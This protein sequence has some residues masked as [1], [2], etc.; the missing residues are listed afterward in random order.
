MIVSGAGRTVISFVGL[1]GCNG[2]GGDS[3]PAARAM[4]LPPA[5]ASARG[6]TPV[7]K[8]LADTVSVPSGFN[9]TVLYRLGPDHGRDGRRS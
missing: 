8:S 6:F 2:D 3:T 4:T 1:G 7:V 9:V 5:K